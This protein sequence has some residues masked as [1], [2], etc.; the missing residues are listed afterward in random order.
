MSFL[1]KVRL[2]LLQFACTKYTF[3]DYEQSARSL[4]GDEFGAKGFQLEL[5]SLLKAPVKNHQSFG[6][7]T[8]DII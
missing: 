7:R 2:L 4:N 5:D 1:F 6:E 3:M 8:L